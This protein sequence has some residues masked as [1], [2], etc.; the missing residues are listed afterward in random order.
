MDTDEADRIEGTP[1][2]RAATTLIGHADHERDLLDAYRSGRLPHAMIFGGPTGIGKA[3]LAWRLAKFLLTNPLPQTPAVAEARDLSVAPGAKAAAQVAALSHPDVAL[4][5][6]EVNEKTKRFYTEIR[7]DDV[8]KAISL[9]QRAAG[10]GGYRIC[11]VDSAED[12][13]RSSANALLKLIEEPPPRSLFLLIAHRPGLILPTIRSRSRLVRL[14]A[15]TGDEIARVVGTLGPPWT[16]AGEAAIAAACA[17]AQ[18]SVHDALRLL[19]HSGV[20]LDAMVGRLL[21]RLPQVD[22]GQVHRLADQVTGRDGEQAFEIATT[23]IFDWLS[24]R[25]RDTGQVEP[26]RLAPYAEVWEKIAADARETDALNLDK[27]PLILSLFADLAAAVRAAS[28]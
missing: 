18:G 13:N 19:G 3:T 9:F 24:R 7:A 26:R 21:E 10:A 28:A 11:I 2:P 15:L 17:Q 16:E 4:L 20:E 25:V 6:R 14:K 8:R 1:H 23:A 5:R 22:W 12:L 27:R